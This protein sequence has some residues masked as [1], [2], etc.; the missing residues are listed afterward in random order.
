MK[1]LALLYF[2]SVV[3]I[4][5]VSGE[6]KPLQLNLDTC[7]FC[8]MT[9]AN[10]HFGAELI[11]Q[12]GRCYK[13]DDVACLIHFAKSNPSVTSPFLFVGDFAMN[14]KLAPVENCVYIKGGTIKSPMNG[15][16]LAFSSK[17]EAQQYQ[18]KYKADILTWKELYNSY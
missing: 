15:N 5:C 4:S 1:R 16:A 6:P 8:R 17:N 7:D 10:A 11:T 3:L 2:A 18:A 9:I 12:K 13:F 14:S